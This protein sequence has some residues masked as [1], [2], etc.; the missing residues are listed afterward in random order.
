MIEQISHFTPVYIAVVTTSL[1]L[2]Y[3]MLTLKRNT[4]A[5]MEHPNQDRSC[6]CD[7]KQQARTRLWARDGQSNIPGETAVVEKL[8]SLKIMMSHFDSL[9]MIVT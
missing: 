1:R 8:P 3:F 7:S 6:T 2:I 9:L 5:K 4:N